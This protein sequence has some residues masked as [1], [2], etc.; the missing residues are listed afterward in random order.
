MT[1][2]LI[3]GL[4]ALIVSILVGPRFIAFLRANEFG[5]HI[6]E[7][8]PEH[9]SSKQ[10]TP[11]MGGLLILLSATIGF[12]PMTHFRL[13]ALT[14]LF[15]TLACGAIGFLDDFIKLTRARSLGLRGRWK[16][17]LLAG[18]TAVVAVVAHHLHLST[19]VYVPIA[20]ISIP[21]SYGWY[22]FLFLIIA[23]ASNGTNL[24]DGIDGLA[25]GT[26]IIAIFTFTAMMIVSFVRSNPVPAHRNLTKLDLAVIGAA[27][28]GA[29][30]GFLWYNAFPAEVI[31]G[32][33]GS[34][35]FGGAI[36]TFAIMTKTEVLL[37]F[38]GG[39]FVIEALSVMIQVF[40]FKYLGR[41][42]FLMAPIH[43]HF[44]MK[45]WSE[46]KIMVRFWIV[47]GILCSA[48]FALY[49]RYYFGQR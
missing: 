44:E 4:V 40:S 46:T 2:V 32:D 10:G 27:L 1:R 7:D 14:V 31:M 26:G 35:A 47:A 42:V 33:T 21:L 36:A 43:H 9:H 24:A 6:R 45:A 25:A 3:A 34:M 37:I 29:A 5:Q 20:N 38:I 41:R 23:G 30:V 39:I 18:V 12:L 16:M 11:T 49:Y 48:G 17:L 15:A 8:G 19:D 22:V 13:Q 28:I